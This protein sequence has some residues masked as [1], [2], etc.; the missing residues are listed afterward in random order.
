MLR[1]RDDE[2]ATIGRLLDAARAGRGG[3]LV[4]HG[5]PGVGKSMLLA[6]AVEHAAGMTVLRTRGVESESPLAFAALQRLLRPVT[7]FAD[8]LAE[9]QAQALR[10]AL[11]E[12]SGGAPD[13][14]LV[15]LAVLNLLAE[16]AER[17]PVLA[18]VDD[19]QW[20][21]Q[22]SSAALLF[23]ARRLEVERV[24]LL[25]AA[26]D[27]DVHRFAGGDLPDAAVGGMDGAAAGELLAARAGVAVPA[28]VRDVLVAGTGGNPLALVELAAA[29]TTAQLSGA[30]PLPARLPLTEG[31]ERAFLDRA[32]RL[33]PAGQAVLL[34]AAADDS[35][36]L[37]TIT[38]AAAELGAGDEALDE[39]EAAGLLRVA[40]GT[41]EL[42]HPLVRSAVYGAA[43]RTE[44]RRAH[45]ALAGALPARDEAD[46]RAWH[47]AAAVDGP[48]ESVVAELDAAA[49][50]AHH[51]GGHEAASA[52]WE[53]AAELSELPGRRATRLFRAASCAWLAAQPPRARALADAALAAADE[54][55]LRADVVGLR[56]NVEFH[57]GSLDVGHRMLLQGAAEAAPHDPARAA[58]MAMVAASLAAFGAGSVTGP[59]P[60]AF[61]PAAPPSAPVRDR[62]LADL[63]RGLDAV[64]H[65]DWPRAVP[66]LRAA[67]TLADQLPDTAS[68]DLLLL[69]LGVA[70][71]HLGDDEGALRLQDRLLTSARTAG[72]VV[73]VLHALTRRCLPEIATGRWSA[74]AAAAAESLDLAERTGQ[75]AQLGLPAALLAVVAALRDQDDADDRIA[76]AERLAA[77]EH[78]GLVAALV[79]DLLRWARA[80]RLAADPVAALHELRQVGTQLVQQLAAVDRI[81]AAV[82]AGDPGT[83]RDWV[84][85]LGSYADATGAPWAEAV[86]AHGR[87]LLADGP[88]AGEHFDRALA[89]HA[90]SSRLPDRARTELAHGEHLRRS[91]RRVDARV[92]LRAALQTFDEL[93]ARAWAERARQ[94]LRASGETVRRRD[95]VATALTPQELQVA[96]L[97]REGLPNRD[98]AA[99][100]FVSPRTVD[101]HLRNVFTKLG[102]SSR[103]ELA[104]RLPPDRAR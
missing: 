103:T 62:C 30:A 79:Q 5:L 51:R 9:P 22:A 95:D 100:L 56:A 67:V 74:A 99:R 88:G 8:R 42:R 18:V 20:L 11:G 89:A 83:A 48:D 69:N 34:V 40:T 37:G 2:R 63:V 70:T 91:R 87:A 90:H 92:H 60:T 39:A 13:R 58:E 104:A 94:E 96:A 55:G 78:L 49:E 97:V 72:A 27:G 25:F 73:W 43:T 65:R 4:L 44:R 10:A 33:S 66:H 53:R 85:E 32:R 1:G 86:A 50:R 46:R 54:P 17:A 82:R 84:D 98:V 41:V 24:A 80:R 77:G 64:A 68:E 61:V 59:D 38:A 28:D 57:A 35:G 102:V 36:R 12:V 26:R 7:G 19:A 3:T 14:F 45:R 71:L 16:A 101:F 15:S 21:D 93:G 47:L 75:R 31:V 52:A 6:D 76:A 81:E 23:V 29:L